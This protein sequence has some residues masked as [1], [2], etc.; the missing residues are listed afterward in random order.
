MSGEYRFKEDLRTA[1][2]KLPAYHYQTI[3]ADPPWA[4][5][6]GGKIKRGA[7]EHYSLMKQTD[8]LSVSY[9][10]KRI[11]AANAHLYL[12]VTNNFLEDGLELT[13]A[14]G[15]EY[16]THGIWDK[17]MMGMGYWFRGQHELLLVATRGKFSPPEQALRISSVIR[18]R[19]SGHSKKPV[20]VRDMIARWYPNADKLEMFARDAGENWDIWGD[21]VESTIR[22]ESL[23]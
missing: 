2:P 5:V 22:I 14:W 18:E 7:D 12:W 20:Y 21:Q 3:Y 23:K 13:K 10:I 6:G 11:C 15:F 9:Q 1:L 19:R 17:E 16:K 8:L 4:E